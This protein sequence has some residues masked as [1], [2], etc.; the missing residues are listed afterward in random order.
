MLINIA[1]INPTVVNQKHKV[2]YLEET[3]KSSS[4]FIPMLVITETHINSNIYDAEVNIDDYNV[5]RSDR[6]DRKGGGVAVYIHHTIT[7]NNV[8][9]Y[10][11]T[12][13]E[14][15][16]L[17]SKHLN[18]VIVGM[19]RP[20]TGSNNLDIHTSFVNLL[21]CVECFCAKLKNHQLIIMGDMNLP[22][23]QW[24]TES[25]IPGK[26]D[27]KCAETFL[28]FLD[29]HFLTQ[30]V[31][32]TTRK[33]KNTLD[34]IVSN[35]A[36]N[37]HSITVEKV[38]NKLSDHDMV[39]C[40]ITDIFNTE[41]PPVKPY[42]P[43]HPLDQLNFNKSNWEGIRNELTAVD[44]NCLENKELN[45]M[46]NIFEKTV[47]S[48]CEKHTP[49]HKTLNKN[50]FIPADRRALIKLKSNLN[51]KINLHKYVIPDT[52][53]ETIDR[54][55]LKKTEV[56]EKIKTS[57]QEEAERKE[58]KMLMQI[59][60]NPKV[61]YSYAKRKNKVKSKIGPLEG[62]NGKF[63]AD[64]KSMA[65]ILPSQ[66]KKAFSNPN[67]VTNINITGNHVNGANITDIE[68]S[69]KDI[70]KAI[71]LIPCQSAGGPDKFPACIL[72]ECKQELALPLYTIWR[73]S[74]DSGTI[75]EIFLQQTIIP[76]HKKDSK[77]K[78]INYR[79]VSLTSHL[80]KLFERVLRRKLVD[81]IETNNLLTKE[82][83]GFRTGMSC[84]SQ[85]LNHF[86][87]ILN[88]LEK[89]SNVDVL[90]LDMS[91][92][93]DK[94]DHAILLRKLESM[95][96]EGKVLKWL[97]AFLTNRQQIVMVNGE[98]SRPEKVLSGVPQGTVLGPILFILYMNDITKVLRHSYIKIFADDS[99][100]IKEINSM[101]DRDLFCEDI[102]AV[103]EWATENKM[104]LNKLKYQL[105]QY[106]K[107]EDLKQPYKIDGSTLVT[108]SDFVKDLG[109][110]MSE[111]LQ[112]NDHILEAKKKAKKVAGW[113]F[114]LV[115]CRKKETIMLLYKT[116]VRPHL[117]YACSV[118]S[119]HLVKH[120]EALEA[121]QRTVTAKIT[122]LENMNYWERLKNLELFSIQRR[123]ERYD[124]IHLFKIHK[125]TIQ[126]DLNLQFY[127][128]P[129]HGWKCRRNIIQNH[130]KQLSKNRE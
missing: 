12:V 11:D 107:N 7:I 113:I 18:Q 95:G 86:E 35:I 63:H 34:I 99:K 6:K 78:A 82:Q 72:K 103:I 14:A 56:E 23:I 84:M 52:K 26:Q 47:T 77:A 2:K 21:S 68:F 89:S 88:L 90:Y 119:P 32:E 17:H 112:F 16:L 118:W 106:G 123:R 79:P 28:N 64:D 29:N 111:T 125:G 33:D 57:I 116:Y 15:V 129:R 54:L 71:D 96:I 100:L 50:K 37:I 44:W 67:T 36:T 24:S 105:L 114:R 22:S 83:Y 59:K 85:L 51:H 74:L 117:E 1:G 122:E 120:I 69:V 102:L 3:I 45:D 104:E 9:T 62:E 58:L 4:N 75:P 66:Y 94:V 60:T 81:F 61:L 97:T 98:K 55:V 92:A 128:T 27:K 20:P 126:N 80:I 101:S 127:E 42:S 130:Q 65:D 39:N 124:I 38:S 108:K 93:F 91:K 13:C 41:K 53:Q 49:K 87:K 46:C 25:V 30:H 8:E 115:E 109:V 121:I 40:Y 31:N 10:S 76:I 5:F 48:V 19:Y 110:L 73:N 43:P 70:E